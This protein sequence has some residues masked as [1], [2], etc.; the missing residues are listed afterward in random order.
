MEASFFIIDVIDGAEVLLREVVQRSC[1][2]SDV[3]AQVVVHLVVVHSPKVC[4]VEVDDP[5]R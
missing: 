2:Q 4:D 5:F 1:R 3:E